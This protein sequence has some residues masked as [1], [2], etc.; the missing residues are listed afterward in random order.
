MKAWMMLVG[1]VGVMVVQVVL[2]RSYLTV[3]RQDPIILNPDR[4]LDENGVAMVMFCG[5]SAD[6]GRE[7]LTKVPPDRQ[8]GPWTRGRTIRGDCDIWYHHSVLYHRG[9][10]SAD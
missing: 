3:N 1:A 5:S 9:G 7:V 4:K 6:S 2:G 10:P 8:L